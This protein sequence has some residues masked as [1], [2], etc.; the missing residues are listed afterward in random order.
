[1]TSNVSPARH[2]Y[3]RRS[4]RYRWAVVWSIAAGRRGKV[5]SS[6]VSSWL[7]SGRINARRIPS[8]SD[9]FSNPGPDCHRRR[10]AGSS[11]PNRLLLVVFAV[12]PAFVWRSGSRQSSGEISRLRTGFVVQQI[13][14]LLA[15]KSHSPS[16][17]IVNECDR[18]CPSA[19]LPV[20]LR[21][22][23]S[24]RGNHSAQGVDL[25]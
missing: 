16:Y 10:G 23:P 25:P 18:R 13:F 6:R 7:P 8:G 11:A 22:V 12:R 1:M 9:L 14:A 15:K 24:V 20:I 4:A 2:V 17:A 21:I 3:R 19:N 5:W